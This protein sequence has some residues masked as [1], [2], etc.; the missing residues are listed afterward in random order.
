MTITVD[1]TPVGTVYETARRAGSVQAQLQMFQMRQQQENF[2]M[3]LKAEQDARQ[4]TERMRQEASAEDY[5]RTLA[6][7]QAKSQIDFDSD[8]QMYQRKR[9]MMM[10]EIEQIQGADFLTQDD[11]DE[12]A[13]RAYG[14]HFGVTLANTTMENFLEKQQYKSA[15]VR[16]LQERVDSEEMSP[17]EARN[18][19]AASGIPYSAN[20][21]VPES[22]KLRIRRDKLGARFRSTVAALEDYKE[23]TDWLGRERV[24]I[25]D[26]ESREW[27]EATPREEGNYERLVAESASLN[28]E[29]LGIEEMS[30]RQIPQ[31]EI[32]AYLARLGPEVRI[33]WDL[34]KAEGISFPEFLSKIGKLPKKPRAPSLLE[35]ISPIGAMSYI[36]GAR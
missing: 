22:E 18:Y 9:M 31:Q 8:I 2:E 11:K 35:K 5:Q 36:A 26:R 13:R 33:G 1:Y 3:R 27:R 4:W 34:A 19:A 28:D 17:E 7:A 25:F 10:S 24:E 16:Q 21:F 30:L 23:G 32:D 6:M 12:L 29:M 20:M 14:K 15:V